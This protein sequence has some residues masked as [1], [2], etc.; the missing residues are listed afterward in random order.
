MPKQKPLGN[1]LDCK[2]FEFDSGWGGTDVTPGN[3]LDIG[4]RKDIWKVDSY[5]REYEFRS[6]MQTAKT[7]PHYE[8]VPCE[9]I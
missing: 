5:C 4:C 1:C 6:L 2:H 8:V 9:S 3:P 7:C